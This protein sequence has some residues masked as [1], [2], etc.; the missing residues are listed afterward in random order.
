MR[1]IPQLVASLSGAFLLL[2]AS[3][4]AVAQDGSKSIVIGEER[5]LFS[6]RLSE[7]RTILVGKPAGYD[8]GDATYPVLFLLDGRDHFHHTTGVTGFLA[9]NELMPA[10]LV[11][12]IPNTV[13]IR[14]L[15]PRSLDPRL[16]ELEPMHGGAENFRSF[17]ADELIPWLDENYRTRPYRILVGHSLGGLFA[18][19][20]LLARPDLFDAYIAISP[21]LHWDGG[22][23]V[24]RANAAFD[25]NRELEASVFMTVGNE[26]NALAG[27]VARF[28]ALLEEKAPPG[29]QWHFEQLPLESHGSVPH[30]STYRALEFIFADWTLRD[31]LATY[32]RYGM[33]GI[34]HFF[35]KSDEKY[36][37]ER[38]LPLSV[39]ARVAQELLEEGRLDELTAVLNRYRDMARPPARFLESVAAAYR[40]QGRTDRAIELYRQALEVSPDSEVSRRALAE[41]GERSGE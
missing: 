12:A 5:T 34:E 11:V 13:R 29:L 41:L 24:E 20:S 26:G 35:R 4:H 17:F 14:D 22:R 28:A 25:S 18:I 3:S 6:E 33:D 8:Q 1:F 2:S 9:R 39:G 37:F 32:N 15:T 10:M 38:G 40:E 23:A 30:R 36:G 16:I 19:D 7:E 27:G 21:S 31:P